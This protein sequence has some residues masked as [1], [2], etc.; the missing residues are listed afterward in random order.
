MQGRGTDIRKTRWVLSGMKKTP[1]EMAGIL[2][3]AM[4]LKLA[5]VFSEA[6]RV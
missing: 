2:A 6:E 1:K 3:E 4:P 5:E